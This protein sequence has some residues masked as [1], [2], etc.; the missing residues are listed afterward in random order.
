M[1][2]SVDGNIADGYLSASLQGNSL[3]ACAY[4]ASL[5]VA[6]LLRILT[7]QPLAVNHS[8]TCDGDIS[9]SVSPYQR[10]MKIGM[11]SVLVFWKSTK[12]LTLV[13]GF[14]GGRSSQQRTACRQV[15][16]D[17]RLQ[18]NAAAEIGTGRQE[19]LSAARFHRSCYGSINGWR[20]E[21]SSITLGTIV[22]DVKDTCQQH[23]GLPANGAKQYQ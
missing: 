14:H 20:V 22:L 23:G 13:V 11:P 8:M 1:A 12:R 9:L 3:V 15:Q 6:C 21:C 7:C 18:A 16:V 19:H 17:V 2:T 5:H 4:R 10:V